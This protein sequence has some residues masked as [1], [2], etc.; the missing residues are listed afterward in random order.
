MTIS[1]PELALF[2]TDCIDSPGW[3]VS[4]TAVPILEP[5]K[6]IRKAAAK[7]TNLLI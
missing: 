3:T 6:K 5:I 2:T 7:V 4:S 1:S